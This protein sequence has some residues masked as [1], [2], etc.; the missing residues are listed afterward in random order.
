MDDDFWHNGFDSY[1]NVFFGSLWNWDFDVFVEIEQV[2]VA[3][4]QR[5]K[6]GAETKGRNAGVEMFAVITKK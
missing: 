1:I 6:V 5:G 4:H 2:R 3:P